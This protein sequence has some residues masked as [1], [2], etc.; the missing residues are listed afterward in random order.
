MTENTNPPANRRETLEWA[1]AR[2]QD[3]VAVGDAS[4]FTA[5]D[6]ESAPECTVRFLQALIEDPAAVTSGG[7]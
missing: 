7:E 3:E 5:E 2:A 6:G 1:L 4:W